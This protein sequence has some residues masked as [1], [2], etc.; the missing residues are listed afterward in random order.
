MS[1]SDRAAVAKAKNRVTLNL[2][3]LLL[4]VGLVILA[5]V[6]EPENFR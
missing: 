6:V 5:T 4:D 1:A 2:S 3:D